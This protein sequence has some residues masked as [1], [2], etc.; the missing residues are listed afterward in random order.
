MTFNIDDI[1]NQKGKIAIVTGANTGLG[2][3]TAL[4]LARMGIRV[5][6][7]CRSREKAEKAGAE[8]KKAVTN[9]NL[10][11]IPLD[12][13]R[14]SSVREFVQVFRSKYDRLDLLI[15][16]A[17][18]MIPPHPKTEDGLESHMGINYYGHFLLTSLLID[19]MPD[20]P[21]S[22]VVSLS[23]IGHKFIKSI[24]FDKLQ[25]EEIDKK[26]D[27]YGM[28]KLACLMFADELD[29]RLAQSGKKILSVSAHPGMAKTELAR[30]TSKAFLF[31]A[32]IT[33]LPL[34]THSIPRATLPTLLAAL[35]PNVKGGD[36][37]GPV[38]FLEMKGAPGPST[39]SEIA[40]DR[41]VA[42]KLWEISKKMTSAEFG[43]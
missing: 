18:V 40:R 31:F 39:R 34:L 42:R 38:G 32:S 21:E 27:W 28:S 25:S 12:L 7:A 14:L 41:E 22:R 10:V 36:Y 35:D 11:I 43:L 16:N 17:G 33:F 29:R 30:H 8:I 9:A 20:T 1:P 2:Y 3:E 26:M 13:N 24:D 5:V 23:S 37:Y 19:M 4:A 6:M 15:N